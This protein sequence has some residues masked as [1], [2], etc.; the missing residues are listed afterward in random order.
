MLSFYLITADLVAIVHFG[1][2]LFVVAGMALILI[3][4]ARGWEWVRGFWFR[5]AHVASIVVVCAQWFAGIPCVLT[6]L[7]NR[8][9]AAGGGSVY[10]HDFLGYWADRLVFYDL[11]PWVFS[12]AYTTFALSI[13]VSFVAAPPRWPRQKIGRG[14]ARMALRPR[15]R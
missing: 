5:A 15:S 2:V 13:V 8:L 6:L 14:S 11:P 4:I 9:R 1:Y 10:A 7:E 12:L 3:G